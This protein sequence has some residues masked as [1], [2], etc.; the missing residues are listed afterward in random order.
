MRTQSLRRLLA[1][2]LGVA[3]LGAASIAVAAPAGAATSGGDTARPAVHL[4]VEQRQCLAA[5]GVTRPIRPL[6]REKI[7]TIKA[8]AQACDVKIPA[9][10]K[11]HLARR[12]VQRLHLT[13]E[14]RQCLADHGVTRPV[15]PLTPEKVATIKAAALACGIHRPGAAVPTT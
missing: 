7:A 5:H 4:T 2:G 9:A 1:T 14:Q 6:T 13:A 12:F 10:V 15:L 8:A 3:A 11:R